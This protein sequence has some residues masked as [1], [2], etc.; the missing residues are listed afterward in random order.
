MSAKNIILLV[1]IVLSSIITL[2]LCGNNPSHQRFATEVAT[3]DGCL[4]CHNDFKAKTVTNCIG[5]DCLLSKSHSIMRPYPPARKWRDYA[6]LR[7]I[8][9]AGCILEQ[10]KTTCL[11]CHMLTKPPPHTIREGDQLCLICHIGKK[12]Q[13]RRK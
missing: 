8:E 13:T 9:E 2:N 4:A 6:S 10:G 7:D 1:F 11:S 3:M 5:N 12:P